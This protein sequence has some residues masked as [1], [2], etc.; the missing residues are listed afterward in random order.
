MKPKFLLIAILLLSLKSFSQNYIP[1][2]LDTSCY[3][4]YD[5]MVTNGLQDCHGESIVFV[6]KDTI[7][8]NLKY[9]KL[10]SYNSSEIQCLNNFFNKG[11]GIGSVFYVRDDSINKKILYIDYSWT[12]KLMFDF[13][14]LV[15]DSIP[16]CKSDINDINEAIIDSMSYNILN[17][18]NRKIFYGNKKGYLGSINNFRI[19]EGVG[20]S[21]GFPLICY[22]FST[23]K[24]YSKGGQILYGVTSQPCLKKP[25]IAVSTKDV[26]KNN[27]TLTYSNNSFQ[28]DNPNNEKL[29]IVLLDLMGNKIISETTNSIYY[30]SKIANSI[31]TGIYFLQVGNEKGRVVKKIGVE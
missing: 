19:I 8:N 15:G 13:N 18:I 2:N 23:L 22:Q 16:F 25:A 14:Y 3:W 30:Q 12:E 24:C 9:A 21:S 28:I 1:M 31:S 6:E 17:G 29:K 26:F 4:V 5:W 10:K 27:F 7:V 11:P 20:G